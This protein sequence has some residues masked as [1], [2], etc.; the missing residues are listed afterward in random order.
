MAQPSSP[1]PAQ[2]APPANRGYAWSDGQNGYSYQSSERSGGWGYSEQDGRGRYWQWGDQF[3][4]RPDHWDGPRCPPPV[5]ANA[6]TAGQAPAAPVYWVA[7]RDAAGY[8]TWP[9]KTPA[10]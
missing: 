10:W 3:G 7:G 8:L 1:P 2:P 9:G 5:P 6:C 4:G